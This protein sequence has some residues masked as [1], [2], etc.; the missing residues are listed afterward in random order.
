LLARGLDSGIDRPDGEAADDGL[1]EGV[2]EGWSFVN[3]DVSTV[4]EERA[5]GRKAS[6]E[7]TP[8]SSEHSRSGAAITMTCA[9]SGCRFTG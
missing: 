5:A 3:A 4:L 7:P 6:A 2:A 8:I 9:G 1:A